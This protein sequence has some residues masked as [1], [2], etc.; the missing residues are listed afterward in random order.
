MK[1]IRHIVC[2]T[3]YKKIL[4]NYIQSLSLKVVEEKDLWIVDDHEIGIRD[5][6]L[7]CACG[8]L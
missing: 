3:I 6:K 1:H 7:F 8:Y 5:E 2:E 4:E